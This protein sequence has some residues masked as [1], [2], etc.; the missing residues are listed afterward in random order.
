MTIDINTY[1]NGERVRGARP[2]QWPQLRFAANGVAL[3]EL[4]RLRDL[5]VPL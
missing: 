1:Q 3:V 5:T 4:L 2:E